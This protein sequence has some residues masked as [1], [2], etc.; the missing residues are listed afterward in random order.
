MKSD[1][2]NALFV[3]HQGVLRT[4]CYNLTKDKKTGENRFKNCSLLKIDS[5]NGTITL[6]YDN[7][8]TGLNEGKESR[9]EWQ[10]QIF[11]S[12]IINYNEIKQLVID[13]FNINNTGY[14]YIY[15]VRHAQ[16]THNLNTFFDKLKKTFSI[17][18][19][20]TDEGREQAFN[21]GKFIEN[22]SSLNELKESI[23]NS[24]VD[25]FVSILGR[26]WETLSYILKA[27]FKETPTNIEPVISLGLSEFSYNENKKPLKCD[28]KKAHRSLIG[29]E[30]KSKCMRYITGKEPTGQCL[31]R[32]YETITIKPNYKLYNC[33][34]AS[35]IIDPYSVSFTIG[36]VMASIKLGF[37]YRQL[38]YKTI[39]SQ[40][41]KIYESIKN[42]GY[43][44]KR[45]KSK[46]KKSKRKTT[47][48][49]TTKRK[50]SKRKTSKRK[51]SKRKTSKRKTT[52]RKT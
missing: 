23:I 29:R 49:K 3:T 21:L 20:L 38:Q 24:K 34:E 47:K 16:G 15:L 28:S 46:R 43:Y 7:K 31:E 2:E 26:T 35:D 39:K 13:I 27:I 4:L 30:N 17:D 32:T 10:I 6:E 22:T 36:A 9:P 45:K 42:A 18:P 37:L 40:E 8:S 33:S 12:H 11:N 5:E 48:R 50:T 52:K 14:K 1:N 41:T 44:K 19:K 51:T 25:Y